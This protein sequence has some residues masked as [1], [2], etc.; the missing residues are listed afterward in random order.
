VAKQTTRLDSAEM[1]GRG[2]TR[3]T[4]EAWAWNPLDGYKSAY[5]AHCQCG[6]NMPLWDKKP[7]NFCSGCG[8]RIIF[9]R[10]KEDGYY[11]ELERL[12]AIPP[13]RWRRQD[14]EAR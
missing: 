3:I 2:V 9:V 4:I 11:R 5:W 13:M 6:G 8:K 10:G 14:A 12:R 1:Q 7:P